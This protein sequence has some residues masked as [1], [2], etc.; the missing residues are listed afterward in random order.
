MSAIGFRG[1]F[2]PPHDS[3]IKFGIKRDYGSEARLI[4]SIDKRTSQHIYYGWYILGVVFVSQ[5]LTIGLITYSFGMFV[6]PVSAEF[7]L[8]RADINIGL[9]TIIAGMN[10]GAPFIGWIL[11]RFPARLV[12]SAG[13]V[14]FGLGLI[15]ISMAPSPWI[16]VALLAFPVSLAAI[17]VSHLMAS[18]MISRWFFASRGRALGFGALS[19]SVSGIVVVKTLSHC[20]ERF[21][22]R[23][24]LGA[25]GAF[26]GVVVAVLALAIIRDRPSDLG[27][28]ID[29]VEATAA[30]QAKIKADDRV[31]R[32]QE[33]LRTRDMWLIALST[34]ILMA[35]DYALLASIVPYGRQKGLTADS[36]AN[37]IA[38]ISTIAFFGKLLSGYLCDKIDK[39]WL[40]S[41]VCIMTILFMVI[42]ST[43]PSHNLLLLAS[44][45]AGL[46]TGSTMPVWYASI[47]QRFGT[48]SYGTVLG[49]TFLIHMPLEMMS[50]RFAGIV[51]DRTGGYE[52]VF[53]TFACLAPIAGLLLLPVALPPPMNF[54]R[55]RDVVVHKA[56]APRGV[57]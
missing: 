36:A 6:I 46:A 52:L 37:L 21:G 55:E 51:F 9:I 56:P 22:W 5:M 19:S 13:V 31:Y 39:R 49:F 20:I 8:S 2:F 4:N 50:I 18:T 54:A 35:I 48:K 24:S 16:I 25:Y 38:T 29:G 1:K 47:A 53:T 17:C 27:I 43:N 41:S 7:K 11:D 42:L 57:S 15:A 23:M 32:W 28:P 45:T 30:A 26:E 44:A 14:V 34:G 40:M 3:V 12:M 33:L 10:L